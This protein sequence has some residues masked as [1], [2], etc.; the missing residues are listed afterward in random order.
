MVITFPVKLELRNIIMTKIKILILSFHF[1]SFNKN[2]ILLVM[3]DDPQVAE[4]LIYD[5]RG[6]KIKGTRNEAGEC[7]LFSRQNYRKIGPILAINIK[8][9]LIIMLLKKL[10]KIVQAN[11][12]I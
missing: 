10:I 2:Y 9:F 12:Q 1:Y 11:F 6:L 7:S 3:L 8:K 4:N 5:Y